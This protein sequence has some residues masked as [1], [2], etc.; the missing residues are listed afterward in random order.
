M[1]GGMKNEAGQIE[2]QALLNACKQSEINLS[3]EKGKVLE[4][5][6]FE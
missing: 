5:D 1:R 2:T 3:S 4:C 6:H